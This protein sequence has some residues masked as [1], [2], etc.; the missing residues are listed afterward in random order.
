MK[1]SQS[2]CALNSYE[3]LKDLDY[4]Y[5][6]G[7]ENFHLDFMDFHYVN[8]FGLK[9][10]DVIWLRNR[11]QKAIFEAHCMCKYSDALIQKL[12]EIK[13]NKISLPS[14]EF[15]VENILKIKKEYPNTKF[16]IMIESKDKIEDIKDQI[17]MLDYVVLMTIDIIGGVG[18]KLNPILFEKIP[19]I[20]KINKNIE[21]ISD[22]GL[23][24]E[25]VLE[26]KRW[27]VDIAVGG[28]ILRN[29]IKEYN[30]FNDF[31]EKYVLIK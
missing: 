13:I 7:F 31:W 10:D 3:S 18:Q 1:Y 23:R 8:S 28:S 29:Y 21:I 27:G 25:N 19:K 26:F 16:G 14:S 22:G 9:L 2:I 15:S 30:N 20:K 17:K 6:N 24:S 5:Q 4:L 12:V 11:Y